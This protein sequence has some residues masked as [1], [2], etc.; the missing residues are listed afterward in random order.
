MEPGDKP[1]ERPA[2]REAL[3][4]RLEDGDERIAQAL[5]AGQDVER[6]EAFWIDLLHQYE[7]LCD[8]ERLA[9]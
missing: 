8:E 5:A 1:S 3:R 4:R 2:Q 6:W 9:A 7:A